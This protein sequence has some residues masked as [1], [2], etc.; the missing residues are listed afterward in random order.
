MNRGSCIQNIRVDR[1]GGVD[2]S[3]VTGGIPSSCFSM[4]RNAATCP[5]ARSI[6]WRRGR[7][8]QNGRKKDGEKLRKTEEL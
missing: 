8:K 4:N 3:Y 6:T 1:T 5:S 2:N 7:K